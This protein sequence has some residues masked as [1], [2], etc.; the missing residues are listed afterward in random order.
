MHRTDL[1]PVLSATS[2]RDSVWIISIFP[3]CTRRLHL[4]LRQT[5][6]TSQSW[7]RCLQHEP[8][9]LH[10]FG[11][12]LHTFSSEAHDCAPAFP[13]RQHLFTQASKYCCPSAVNSSTLGGKPVS[14]KRISLTRCAKV[15]A[16]AASRNKRRDLRASTSSTVTAYS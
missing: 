1:A 7:A 2:N 12:N 9:A 6:S 3:T 14:S 10:P 15:R 4:P 8:L 13:L 5:P 16:R 11:Q